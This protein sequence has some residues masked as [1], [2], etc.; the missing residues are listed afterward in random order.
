[1]RKNTVLESM[2][3]PVVS[4][5]GYEFVGLEYMP[6]GKHSILRIFIDSENGITLDDCSAVSRQV[7]AVLDVEDPI[8]GEYN[9]EVSSP[10]V[11]RPLFTLD[12]FRKFEG[13]RC[14]VRMKVPIDGQ[15]K[16]TGIIRAVEDQHIVLA[17][18]DKEVNLS[19]DLLDKA[20]LVPE[21]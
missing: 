10:G 4:G 7:S 14:V 8:S 13:H 21:F 15:R 1:M 19:F 16:F 17:M 11:D 18:A 3:E 2:I 5:L 6:Q 9:L 20:S 12:H